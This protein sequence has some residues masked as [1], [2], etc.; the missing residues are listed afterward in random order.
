MVWALDSPIPV[1]GHGCSPVI[2][3]DLLHYA[4]G[5]PKSEPIPFLSVSNQDRGWS[6]FL[7]MFQCDRWEERFS[8]RAVC[9]WTNFHVPTLSV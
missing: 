5:R 2:S 6:L 8:E 4:E 7:P 3:F 9:W 1:R